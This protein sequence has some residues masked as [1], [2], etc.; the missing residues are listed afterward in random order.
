MYAYLGG[1]PLPKIKRAIISVYDKSGIINFAK[2]LSALGI[3]IVSTG[4]TYNTLM[5]NDISATKISCLTGFPEI[6]GGRVKTLHPNIHAGILARRNV[7]EDIVDI[8]SKMIELI[9]MVVVNLYPF[10]QVV[11]RDGSTFE[12]VIENIDIG[13][14]AM[15]RAAAKNYMSVVVVT[16]PKQYDEII[17]QLEVYG[18]LNIDTRQRLM[19]EAFMET[20]NY[21]SMIA[22]QMHNKFCREFS[23]YFPIPLSKVMDLRYGENPN[24]KAAFYVDPFAPGL[25]VSKAEQL[26]G[27]QLS[28]NNIL[29]I[30]KALDI[31]MDF[32]KPTAVIMKHTNPCG[33]ASS[34]NIYDAFVTAYNVDPMSAFGCVICL[35]RNCDTKTAR[36]IIK[37]FVESIICPDFDEEAICILSSRKN[38]R[39]LRTN[40]PISHMSK[41]HEYK[42]KKIRGGMLIQTDNDL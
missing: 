15:I 4:G 32:D 24:Q 29:D 23:E 25:T 30:D 14:P 22:Y 16:N 5:N 18:D 27:K 26:H 42:M 17:H 41:C 10:K 38:I 19:A 40:L 35:N 33:I 36:E 8:E 2:G 12:D 3:E 31:C 9:D 34:S 21:D 37:H 7:P 20:A 13:G 39:L 6:L 1:I 11:L 28:Y